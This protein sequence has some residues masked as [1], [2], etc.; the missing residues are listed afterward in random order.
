MTYLH[1][2]SLH[3]EEFKTE[4][5]IYE[6]YCIPPQ[7]ILPARKIKPLFDDYFFDCFIDRVLYL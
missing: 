5:E 6:D 2:S 1:W 4:Y 3:E 7:S